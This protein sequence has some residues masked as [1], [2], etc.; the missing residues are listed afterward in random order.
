MTI[1]HNTTI[2]Q[3]DHNLLYIS[4]HNLNRTIRGDHNLKISHNITIEK[5]AITATTTLSKSHNNIRYVPNP[6]M[7]NQR[8]VS[9]LLTNQWRFDW[10]RV[11]LATFAT[12]VSWSTNRWARSESFVPTGNCNAV[13]AKKSCHRFFHL[14]NISRAF[15]PRSQWYYP[16]S[17]KCH[18]LQNMGRHFSPVKV[19][20]GLPI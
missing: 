3:F 14:N 4:Q 15:S 1:S 8:S 19:A 11:T 10:R 12:E 5:F 2:R 13:T 7:T 16:K 17:I 18:F 6:E 20:P 9:F